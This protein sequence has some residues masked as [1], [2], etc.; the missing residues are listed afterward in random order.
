MTNKRGFTL[1]ELLVV[2]AI[3]A[4]LAAILFPVFAKAREKARQTS[5]LSNVRQIST[6]TL[7]YAQD[8]D[9]LAPDYWYGPGDGF[10]ATWMEMVNPYAKNEQI[11][12][13]PSAPTSPSGM[14][15]TGAANRL[16]STYTWPAWIRYTYYDW[17]GTIMFAGFPTSADPV[18]PWDA[19]RTMMFVEHPAESTWLIEGYVITY[20]PA[21]SSVFGS[22]ATTGIGVDPT[23]KA[24]YRHN[25]GMNLGFCD[26]HAKFVRGEDWMTNSSARTGGAYSGYPESP[27]MQVG[28]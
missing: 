25:E 8:Y 19:C 13:C 26:G 28:P 14:G 16:A 24:F 21:G 15:Y 1:I 22:A 4:I 23:D 9:E 11:F 5:C 3:I 20:D 7:S 12:L 27:Y 2:I 18:N 10:W 6:A 17:W